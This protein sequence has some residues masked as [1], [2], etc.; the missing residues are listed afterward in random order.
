MKPALRISA[1]YDLASTLWFAIPGLA[2]KYIALFAL[3]HSSMGLT[4]GFPVFGDMHMAFVNLFGLAIA[5]WA[6]A[7]WLRPS[8]FLCML[9]ICARAAFASLL[10][11]HFFFSD[12][13]RI[14][15]AFIPPEIVLLAVLS[16]AHRARSRS[17]AAEG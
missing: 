17:C 3:L 15:G 14:L 16:H 9:D 11:Y 13:S 7:R 1:A 6:L 2:G 4:G 10:A 8:P 12:V 5:F